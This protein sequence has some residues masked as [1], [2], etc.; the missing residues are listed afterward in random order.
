MVKTHRGCRIKS[1]NATRVCPCGKEYYKKYF[2]P[3]CQSN[4]SNICKINCCNHKYCYPCISKWC[5]ENPTCPQCR[6]KITYITYKGKRHKINSLKDDV[7]DVFVSNRGFRSYLLCL[8]INDRNKI[9]I[10]MHLTNRF[11]RERVYIPDVYQ[12][13]LCCDYL[14]GII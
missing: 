7:Y 2:C 11:L 3:I 8:V 4:K 6:K 9:S 12:W 5:E 13:I 14:L 10:Y 1:S